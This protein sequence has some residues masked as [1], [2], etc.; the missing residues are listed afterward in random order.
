MILISIV[1]WLENWYILLSL[2]LNCVILFMFWLSLCK[3][4]AKSILML[5]FEFYDISRVILGKEFFSVLTVIFAYMLIVILIGLVAPLLVG[6]LLDILF[7][8]VVL[9][10]H[11][12][13]KSN[14][15]FLVHLLKLSICEK[16]Q[17]GIIQPTRIHSFFQLADI[18]T[19]ALGRCEFLSILPKLGNRDLHTLTWGRVLVIL[20]IWC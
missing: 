4:L 5:L 2:G 15:L 16:V 18:F 13:Q 9:L 1:G 14:W 11:G 8:L 3:L 19:K 12:R 10:S 7:F 17:R 20:V 6:L